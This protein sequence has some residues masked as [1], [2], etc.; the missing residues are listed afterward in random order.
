MS[1]DPLD[2]PARPELVLR[3]GLEEPARSR[4]LELACEGPDLPAWRRL[5]QRLLLF[6]GTLLL[7]AGVVC[8]FAFNWQ[9]L[10]RFAKFGLVAAGVALCAAG[11][12]RLGFSRTGGKVLLLAASVLVGV[13]LALHGQAYQ[14]GA[15]PY[16]LFRGW[17][18][19]VLPWVLLA[20][21]QALWAFWILLLNLWLGLWWDQAGP[22]ETRWLPAAI[23]GLNGLAWLAWEG[24]AG[25]LDWLRG[26]WLPRVLALATLGV[27]TV[28]ALEALTRSTPRPRDLWA[29]PAAILL[30]GTMRVLFRKLR[31]DLFMVTLALAAGI[32]LLTTWLGHLLLHNWL[33]RDGACGSLLLL[34]LLL[35]AQVGGAAVWLKRLNREEP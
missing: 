29:V 35:V 34:G 5:L 24:F 15:D 12:W 16:E 26:R 23:A 17:A 19:L 25:R 9:G 4:A 18:L 11:A 32:A 14:T 30:G 3:L 31:R 2:L 1:S 22:S 27:L 21:F 28:P 8:F 13:W 7:L 6:A 20:R 33:S 10:H